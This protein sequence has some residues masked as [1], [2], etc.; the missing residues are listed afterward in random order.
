MCDDDYICTYV[1]LVCPSVAVKA[2]AG[3]AEKL[4]AG[5]KLVIAIFNP[6]RVEGDRVGICEKLPSTELLESRR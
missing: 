4:I 3:I 6:V 1:V 2:Q 5:L